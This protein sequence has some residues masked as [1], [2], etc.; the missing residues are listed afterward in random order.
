MFTTRRCR[1]FYVR[2]DD[3]GATLP[4]VTRALQWLR[5]LDEDALAGRACS[6]LAIT[7]P[8]ALFVCC[9]FGGGIG[10]LGGVFLGLL[11][12]YRGDYGV[13][14]YPYVGALIG[15]VLGCILTLLMALR[16][17]HK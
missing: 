4:D 8:L 16:S 5:R 17:R 1:S 9:I 11:P 13:V 10:Y 3:S 15:V 2:D 12:R 14:A 7:I 6:R